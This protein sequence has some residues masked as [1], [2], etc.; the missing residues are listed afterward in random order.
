LHFLIYLQN[1]I[2]NKEKME[3]LT[4]A[5][6]KYSNFE[7]AALFGEEPQTKICHQAEA[8]ATYIIS[9]NLRQS[10]QHRKLQGL[11]KHFLVPPQQPSQ[12]FTRLASICTEV[13]HDNAKF[14]DA[15]PENMNIN[16]NNAKSVYISVGK[17]VFEDGTINWGRVY[18]VLT[19]AATWAVYFTEKGQL[20]VVPQI[21]QWFR[22]LVETELVDW[23][24]EQGGWDAS[25]KVASNSW[26]RMIAYGGVIAAAGFLL[27]RNGKLS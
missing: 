16:L 19:L 2:Q 14:F 22:E 17:T 12:L 11:P 18:T 3:T 7:N 9:Y 10:V 23:I 1:C 21:A 4:M 26:T 13:K 15:L 24:V 5:P 6:Y 27:L 20:S 25:C 8:I